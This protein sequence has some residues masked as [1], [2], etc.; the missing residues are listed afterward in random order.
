MRSIPNTISAYPNSA[1][2]RAHRG[3]ISAGDRVT[4]I[5]LGARDIYDEDVIAVAVQDALKAEDILRGAFV[6]SGRAN[7]TIAINDFED[8]LH[9]VADSLRLVSP[10]VVWAFGENRSVI[11]SEVL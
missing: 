9:R 5:A 10:Q 11:S 7:V 1:E 2:A 4:V 3:F 8:L 6:W